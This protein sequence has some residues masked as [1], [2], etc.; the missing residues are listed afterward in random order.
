MLHKIIGWPLPSQDDIFRSRCLSKTKTVTDHSHPAHH[1]FDLL[2]CGRCF[3]SI[4]SHTRLSKGF[5]PWAKQLAKQTL[6]SHLPPHVHITQT[7]TP[8]LAQRTHNLYFSAIKKNTK[9]LCTLDLL[10]CHIF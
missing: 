9:Q 1:L 4:K 2:P 10:K 7:Y 3:G 6:T 5:F 8:P